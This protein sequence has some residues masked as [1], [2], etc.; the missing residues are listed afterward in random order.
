MPKQEVLP[1]EPPPDTPVTSCI[2]TLNTLEPTARSND[3]RKRLWALINI[4]ETAERLAKEIET[5]LAPWN[6]KEKR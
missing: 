6:R 4:G 1:A 5:M 2:K 3:S